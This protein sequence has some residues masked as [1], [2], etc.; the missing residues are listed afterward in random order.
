MRRV[1][2]GHP[3]IRDTS[4]CDSFHYPSSLI[5]V[6]YTYFLNAPFSHIIF[7]LHS[8]KLSRYAYHLI[9]I[10]FSTFPSSTVP[11]LPYIYHISTIYL[12]FNFSIYFSPPF[13]Q[14]KSRSPGPGGHLDA[15]AA[16]GPPPASELHKFLEPPE[17]RRGRPHAAAQ[18]VRARLPRGRRSAVT[19]R[20]SHGKE[21]QGARGWGRIFFYWGMCWWVL[22]DMFLYFFFTIAVMSWFGPLKPES[23]MVK[24]GGW[25]SCR[26]L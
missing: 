18:R 11:Y 21:K 3:W 25:G 8:H 2:H 7:I 15:V 12:P 22:G 17:P 1:R 5:D 16:A 20:R 6:T 9:Y 23:E 13:P 14:V 26:M 19:A 10:F 24:A 4:T